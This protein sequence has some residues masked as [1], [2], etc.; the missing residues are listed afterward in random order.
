MAS[1]QQRD[2]YRVYRVREHLGLQDPD[3][4]P[5]VT[6]YHNSIFVETNNNG[7][8]TIYQV[9]GD[10]SSRCGM[11]YETNLTEPPDKSVSF[12]DKEL[13]GFVPVKHY[14]ADF[15]EVC[16]A[17]PS[18]PQQ[19]AYNIQANQY[20]PIKPDRTLYAPGKQRVPLVKCTEWTEQQ[21]IPALRQAGMIISSLPSSTA[22][23]S[24]RP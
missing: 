24:T 17:Q 11:Y 16:R 15:D 6:R 18:P 22:E 8:G 14:P 12:F 13:L 5:N 21:A 23:H 10:V 1:P 4:D 2:C 20:Q 19:K 7:S 9:T 3:T